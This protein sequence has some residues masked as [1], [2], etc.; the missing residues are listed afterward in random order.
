M[1]RYIVKQ[2]AAVWCFEEDLGDNQ[3][4]NNTGYKV[5]GTS[6]ELVYTEKD[7]VRYVGDRDNNFYWI[8]FRLPEN[9]KNL[10]YA[11][12][13]CNKVIESFPLDT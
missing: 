3:L 13:E 12:F 9:D 6:R 1:K 5:N 11:L 8:L 4:I 10:K 7:F 2:E